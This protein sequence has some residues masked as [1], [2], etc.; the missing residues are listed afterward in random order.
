M[1][2]DRIDA[3]RRLAQELE[4]FRG[5]D[6]LVLA[7]PRGGVVL[8]YEVAQSLGAPL[9]IVVTRK[10]GHPLHPEYAIG[11]V[12]EKGK[13]L[14][15]EAEAAGLDP[16]WLD[17]ETEKQ[18][19]EAARRIIAYRGGRAPA[20]IA[21]KTVILVDDGIATGLTMRL[22][23]R[24]VR[25]GNPA[26][27]IVAVPVASAESLRDLESEG[28]DDII[29]LEP[30]ETFGGAVGRHYMHFEQ[31]DDREVIRILKAR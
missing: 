15:N 30:P 4:D 6:T 19:N 12:D 21:A 24:I 8:G 17:A 25:E 13:R 27:I 28:V 20:R 5:A 7:L 31:V 26:R 2:T 18:R 14:L 16:Q 3:G 9:D 29:V 23:A 1:F 22:A 10:I 11:V